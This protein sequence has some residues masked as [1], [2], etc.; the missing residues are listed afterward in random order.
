MKYK[1]LFKSRLQE[2][3]NQAKLAKNKKVLEEVYPN[4]AIDDI[5]LV[6]LKLLEV[7]ELETMGNDDILKNL[8]RILKLVDS[9]DRTMGIDE[10]F[11]SIDDLKN[12]LNWL[13]GEVKE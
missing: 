2:I 10:V 12:R 9:I 3:V 11:D 8:K 1:N 7:L 4:E 13:I 6:S 5:E